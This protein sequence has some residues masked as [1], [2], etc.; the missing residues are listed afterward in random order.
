MLARY[1]SFFAGIDY[2][3]TTKLLVILFLYK[4]TPLKYQFMKTLIILASITVSIAMISCKNNAP[5]LE[6][7]NYPLTKKIAQTDDYFGT[8]VKD[9][10]RWLENDT[11]AET[12]AWVVAE[13]KVTNDYLAKIPFRDQIHKRLETLWDFPKMTVPIKKGD[14]VIFEKNDG[15]QNQSVIYV[16]KGITGEPRVLIDPN[17]LS[18]DGTVAVG[19]L[20]VSHDKKYLAY[21]IN[22]A[23]SDWAEFNVLDIETGKT[24]PDKIEWVKFSGAS[25]QGDG[26]YYSRY[27]APSKGKELSN[28]NEYHKVYFH[29]LGTQQSDDKLIFEN[30]NF[31]L[32]SY[33]AGTTEDEHFLILSESEGTSGNSLFCKDITAEGT[34]F[35][36]LASGFDNEYSVADNIGDKLLVLTNEGAPNRKL[37]LIDPKLPTATNWKVIIPEQEEVLEQVV[38]AGDQMFALYMKDATDRVFA[39]SMDGKQLG[40]LQLPGLGAIAGFNSEKGD[41]TVFYGFTSFTFPPT[42]YNYDVSKKTSAEFFKPKLDFD[43]SIYETKQVFY[44]SKD[45]TKIPMFIVHKKGIELDGKNPVLLYGYGGFNISLT[46]NFS[47]SLL[48]FLENGGIYCMPNLRGGGEYGEKWHEAGTK[49]NKQNVFD[50]FIA[51]AEYLISE[52]YTSPEKLAIWG[53]S[54]G[55]L[56]VGACMTQRPDLFKVCLPAVG[57]MDMLRYH[58]FTIG[59]A[60]ASDYGNSDDSTQFRNLLSYSPLHTIKDSV[61]YPATLVTTADHDDRVVPAHSFKFAATLQ[62]K[63]VCNNPVLIRIETK[64]GHGSGKPTSKIIDEMTDMY[65]FLFF[66]LGIKPIK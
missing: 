23:G 35:V 29:K 13:N 6:R 33:Y 60:W 5:V 46:P 22:K 9:P 32:R 11:S 41:N 65:S 62:E 48:V 40:E 63:Q 42:I 37:V 34:K 18:A 39:Y 52:K 57:V 4:F 66:N 44:E 25:W 50:D 30:R 49:L 54:N 31:P 10:Y 20:S 3:N 61:C 45:K 2:I 19:D 55:G 24:L 59:W 27:D 53:G 56:L 64:A 12:S 38:L 47:V 7:I 26:F 43:A 15:M 17:T 36:K 28:R 1:W 16:Q 8:Q 14:W 51:A 21:S 58:K